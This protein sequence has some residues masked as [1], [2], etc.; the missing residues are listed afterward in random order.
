MASERSVV[1]RATKS[2]VFASTL[3]AVVFAALHSGGE[4]WYFPHLVLLAAVLGFV[5]SRISAERSAG[6]VLAAGYLVPILL[7]ITIWYRY[8]Y[9][10]V[11]AAALLGII[12]GT[13]GSIWQFPSRL[14]F[15]LI[16]W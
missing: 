12:A 1:E 10:S 3:G 4:V 15:P 13:T 6:V 8:F 9:L 5:A 2:A 14:R 16:A 7:L 11:W